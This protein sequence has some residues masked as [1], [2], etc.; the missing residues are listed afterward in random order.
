MLNTYHKIINLLGKERVF[1]NEPLSRYST[2]HIGG[3]A[4]LFFKAGTSEELIK[5]I[6]YAREMKIP[7][8]LL[9]GGTN[10]LISDS[11]FR[12]LV[13]KNETKNIKLVGIKGKKTINEKT[14]TSQVVFLEVDSGVSVNRLVRYA[15]DQGFEGLENFLGQPGSVGGGVFINAHN[16]TKGA[17]LGDILFSAQLLLK[18]GEKKNVSHNYFHF[19]YDESI[20]QK[21]QDIVISVVFKLI[22]SD[23]G[24]L[25][26]KAQEA[27]KYRRETQPQGVFSSGCTFRNIRKSDAIRLATPSYTCSAGYLLDAVGL[28]GKIFGKAFFSKDHANFITHNGGAK[29]TDVLE[30]IRIAKKSVFEKFGISLKEEIILVGNF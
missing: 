9:G 22:R 17:F 18:N 26:E 15:L 19:G 12:G 24:S 14:A 7:F 10:L 8:F 25:W 1:I 2:L 3:S 4:D 6:T 28:K 30:L 16:L 23:K 29:A 27:L 20:I 21:T 5:A 13:V 11:G